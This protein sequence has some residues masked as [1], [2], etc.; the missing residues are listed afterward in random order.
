MMM[1]RMMSETR[2]Y[3]IISS[4][5]LFNVVLFYGNQ[6]TSYPCSFCLS[7]D[8]VELGVPVFNFGSFLKVEII[9]G[10]CCYI[11]FSLSFLVPLCSI[12][13]TFLSN[14]VVNLKLA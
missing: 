5:F 11:L 7:R 2:S 4:I 13:C 6:K 1:M 3:N 8:F 10:S 14:F 9:C 12:T